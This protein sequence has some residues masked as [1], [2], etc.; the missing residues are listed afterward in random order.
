MIR[1]AHRCPKL[2]LAS[3]DSWNFIKSRSNYYFCSCSCRWACS[4]SP[5]I[6]EVA[7][8]EELFEVI[9]CDFVILKICLEVT[10]WLSQSEFLL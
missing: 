6:Y 9:Q 10:D 3:L 4:V 8:C 7:T 1:H 2:G 5:T